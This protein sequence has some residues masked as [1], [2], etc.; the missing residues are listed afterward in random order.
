MEQNDTFHKRYKLKKLIGKGAFAEVWLAEDNFTKIEVALKIFVPQQD[1]GDYGI[2]LLSS[3]FAVVANLSNAN[4]LRPIHYDICKGKP[5]LVLP[6]CERGSCEKLIGKMTENDAWRL[7]RDISSGLD[8]LHTLK[9]K[10][11]IHQDIKPDNILIGSNGRYLLS[12]FGVSDQTIL[13]ANKAS[14]GQAEI[15]AG[16]HCY[17]GPEFFS[18]D[19]LSIKASDIYSLG[20]TVY[21]LLVGEP[22]FGES[23]GLLQKLGYDVPQLPNTYSR[24]LNY[25]I[26]RC[27]DKE[28][29]SR[30]TADTLKQ[31]VATKGIGLIKEPW[32]VVNEG[33]KAESSYHRERNHNL[34]ATVAETI[35]QRKTR[36]KLPLAAILAICAIPVI[37][38]VLLLALGK[39]EPK[40]ANTEYWIDT[41]ILDTTIANIE[42]DSGNM[43]AKK[44]DQP[45][46]TSEQT[47]TA[48]EK[49]DNYGNAVYVSD[50]YKKTDQLKK[51]Q[52]RKERSKLDSY[53]GEQNKAKQDDILSKLPSK[54]KIEDKYDN[55]E[56]IDL[57]KQ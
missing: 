17:K 21:E 1:I 19:K 10:P 28:P 2:N 43:A 13:S 39:S 49:K 8:Y 33:H 31:W 7:L 50:S 26:T 27:L 5:Y 44:A 25:V 29:W 37:A 53:R 11:I 12:D 6:Y 35:A 45:Q 9:P 40:T 52:E 30:P 55:T 23:G 20:A 57:D 4:L 24:E 36:H 15:G 18:K 51:K 22:P 56:I 14:D 41:P 38:L 3:E 16:V 47:E 54:S 42:P 32:P 48:K 34:S 46:T